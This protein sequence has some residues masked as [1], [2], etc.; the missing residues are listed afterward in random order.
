MVPPPP[1]MSVT[2]PQQGMAVNS[3]GCSSWWWPAAEL[4]CITC[5]LPRY[6]DKFTELGKVCSREGLNGNQ[7]RMKIKW[8]KN[9]RRARPTFLRLCSYLDDA[10]ACSFW[11]APSS[12]CSRSLTAFSYVCLE[13]A[14]QPS[15]LAEAVFSWSQCTIQIYWGTFSKTLKD[16]QLI[17]RK[18]F[19]VLSYEFTSNSFS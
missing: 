6:A 4:R 7:F 10:T 9:L 17:W 18:I 19:F 12:S 3:V 13:I 8:T 16:T 15:N 1:E 14:M 2:G 11:L 5:L